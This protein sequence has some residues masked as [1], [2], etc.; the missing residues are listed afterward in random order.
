MC[1]F[2]SSP[3]DATGLNWLTFDRIA[4]VPIEQSEVI[5]CQ[6]RIGA[7]DAASEFG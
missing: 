6:R 7:A 2:R 4:T 5:A 1:S 3:I